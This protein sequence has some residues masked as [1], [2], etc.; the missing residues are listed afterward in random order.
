MSKFVARKE[1]LVEAFI[2]TISDIDSKSCDEIE[3]RLYEIIKKTRGL[4]YADQYGQTSDKQANSVLLDSPIL[5]EDADN[6]YANKLKSVN[7]KR[8]TEKF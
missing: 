3:N 5:R 8:H 1:K 6:T 7:M 4:I 2:A